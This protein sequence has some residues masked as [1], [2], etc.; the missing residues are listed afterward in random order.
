MLVSVCFYTSIYILLILL[1][2]KLLY[3]VILSGEK[4]LVDGDSE[5]QMKQMLDALDFYQHAE[6]G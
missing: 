1:F 2:I 3:W 5:S 6:R 4:Q